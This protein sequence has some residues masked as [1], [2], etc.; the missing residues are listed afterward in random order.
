MKVKGKGTKIM[1]YI[2]IA[3]CSKGFISGVVDTKNDESPLCSR[4]MVKIEDVN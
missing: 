2:Y 3:V 4:V 1:T